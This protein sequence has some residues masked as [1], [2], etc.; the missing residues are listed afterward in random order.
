MKRERE[1]QNTATC[2]IKRHDSGDLV[3]PL[4]TY[5]NIGAKK[6]FY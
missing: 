4:Y 2:K 1:K 3:D 6:D 5:I